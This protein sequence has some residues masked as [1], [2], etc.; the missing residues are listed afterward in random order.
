MLVLHEQYN[1]VFFLISLKSTPSIE[2]FSLSP[3]P[4]SLTDVV[5]VPAYYR[6]IY[7][8]TL[9]FRA[10]LPRCLAKGI[11]KTRQTSYDKLCYGRLG[12]MPGAREIRLCK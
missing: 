11:N 3:E 12:S 7:G 6:L 5:V 1:Y 9:P 10:P 4:E 8:H 2:K